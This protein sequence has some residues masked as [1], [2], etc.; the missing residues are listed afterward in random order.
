MKKLLKGLLS[1]VLAYV[2]IVGFTGCN[3][4]LSKTTATTTKVLDGTNGGITAVYD[5][6]L[7]FINGTKKNDGT[8]S[9]GNKRGGI[10]RVKY[11][12]ETGEI[13]DTTYEVI[14]KDLVGYSNGSLY[15]FGDF[16]YYTTPSSDVN[17]KDTVLYYKTKFMR[18]DLVNKKSHHIYTTK[19]NSE[20]TSM[21]YAY[22]VV[23]DTLNLVV[24]ESKSATITSLKIDDKITENYVIE[25]VTSCVMSENNGKCVTSGKTI[26]ANNFVYYTKA[27]ETGDKYQTGNIVYRTSPVKNNDSFELLD[28]GKSISLLCIRNG[29]LLYSYDSRFYF[30]IING[31]NQ[32]SLNSSVNGLTNILSFTSYENVVFKE[33]SDG[34]ITIIYY[35]DKNLQLVALKWNWASENPIESKTI[36]SLKESEKFEFVTLAN[37]EELSDP[38]DKDSEKVTSTYL[39]Y[40]A[41]SVVFKIKVAENGEITQ[42]TQPVKLTTT[43]VEVASGLMVAEVVGDKLYIFAKELDEKD[44]QTENIYLYTV[45]MLIT[46]DSTKAATFIGVKED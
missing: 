11:N 13:D 25:G 27:H 33:N 34:T 15:F 26:D 37:V 41:D 3:N 20:D 30:A 10:A 17:Y 35:D 21:S 24:Y 44:K 12:S 42:H 38:L 40:I 8:N 16:M 36:N 45:D 7:Y 19:L 5:G 28:D 18:Y 39:V 2:C 23:D 32:D 6:Y 14:V 9:S 4:K 43:K 1:A 29:K 22:Y 31:D 46:E